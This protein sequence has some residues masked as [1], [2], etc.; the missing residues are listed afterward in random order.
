MSKPNYILQICLLVFFAVTIHENLHAQNETSQWFLYNK[1]HYSFNKDTFKILPNAPVQIGGS[2][3]SISDSA[4][5]MLLVAANG[6]IYDRNYNKLPFYTGANQLYIS[7][8][9]IYFVRKPGSSSQYYFFYTASPSPPQ[10]N[11]Y[12]K[13]IDL[14]LNGGYGD[15]TASDVM[16]DNNCSDGFT[17]I[18]AYKNEEFWIVTHK[19]NTNDFNSRKVTASGINSTPVK[20]TA[21]MDVNTFEYNYHHLK[22]SPNGKFIAGIPYYY[23]SGL[24]PF[25]RR[26]VE[27]YNFNS[28]TGAVTTRV[29][30]IDDGYINTADDDVEFSAD[31]RLLYA[32]Y[33]YYSP[34]LQPCGFAGGNIWQYNL[35][36]T[37]SVS[38]T[39]YKQFL[40]NVFSF[41]V[42][43]LWGNLQLAPD[44]KIYFP[45]SGSG[46]ASSIQN[47]NN[48]GSSCNYKY[49][50][51]GFKNEGS[52]ILPS[53]YHGYLEK[54]VTNNIFYSGGCYPSPLRFS[55]TND[56][57]QFV[58][59]NFDDI[60]SGANNMSSLTKPSH[61]FSSPGFYNVSAVLFSEPGKPFD[62]VYNL[63]EIKDPNKRLLSGFPKDTF[64]C[65]G[66]TVPVH[67]NVVNGIFYWH[68]RQYGRDENIG[69]ADS[70]LIGDWGDGTYIVEMHQNDCDGCILIDSITF[71]T[72]KTP[73]IYLGDTAVLCSGD[74]LKLYA[75]NPGAKTT[76][77]TGETTQNI[78]VHQQGLYWVQQEYNNNGCVRRDSVQVKLNPGV[79]FSLPRDTTLC[80]NETLLLKPGVNNAYYT[81]QDYSTQNTY[82]VTK[83]GKY[84]VRITNFS[85]CTATDTINVSYV[86]GNA[87]Y[88]GKDTTLCEGDSLSLQSNISNANYL[89]STGANTNSISVKTTGDYWVKVS[90]GACTVSD[91]INVKF[92]KK[93]VFSLGNDTTLCDNI[94]LTLKSAITGSYLWQDGSTADNYTV[95][96][97]GLYWLQLTQNN[98]P[99]TDSIKINYKPAP[100]LDLGN[101]T[102]FCSGGALLL[103]AYNSS[104]ASYIWQN[105]STQSSFLVTQAGI[106]Y[107]HIT[108][109][110]GCTNGDTVNISVAQPPVFSL[111]ADTVLCDTK[112]LDY[113]FNIA[114]ASYRWSDGSAG[115]QYS[116][117]KAGTYWLAVSQSGCSA[118]DTVTVGYKPIPLV[119]LGNDTSLCEGS[120]YLLNAYNTG[121]SYLWQDN[122]AQP[123]YTV[124]KQG[125]YFV[126]VTLDGCTATDTAII[127]Y[128]FKPAFSLGNDTAI[129]PGQTLL[130]QPH[131]GGTLN[132]VWQDG[133]VLDHYT[134][135]G[136]GLYSLRASNQC[137]AATDSVTIATAPCDLEM[138]TAFTPNHD[139]KNDLFRIKYPGFIKDF[140]MIIYNR[141]GAKIFETKDA[142]QGWDGN[143]N[144]IPQN[145]GTYVWVIRLTD[146]NNQ[147]Q[148]SQGLVTLLR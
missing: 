141:W 84:W 36:Y 103:D 42:Y 1:Q 81:W 14:S 119:D 4:E 139:G 87:V 13:L 47:A 18:S 76:W 92:N 80:N 20:S 105:N 61:A 27:V 54:A 37:D 52:N 115:N 66:E 142:L 127:N 137:G 129:C 33:D 28:N 29:K 9:N 44:K 75:D 102:G 95:Q 85:G 57:L 31:S 25:F 123:A 12:Y 46:L 93:P 117:N 21:G 3:T 138:P 5:K 122:S 143:I 17:V 107:V 112:S 90:N 94:K 74:S 109:N 135:T 116:I 144:G 101:D 96:T 6:V 100:P 106:Y 69:T 50:T 11:V 41:C 104:V 7:S 63:V 131:P 30:S 65:E 24:F 68:V 99:F 134:V 98:C 48:I 45:Y 82:L 60:A 148:T 64:L 67:L 59:W 114:G 2:T 62:T 111:G 72:L 89:W 32:K 78:W 147:V 91:T 56:T 88:L 39:N 108:G 15:V 38:F 35:C 121:A 26:F 71:H 70:M 130:L 77:S 125:V 118:A 140:D 43:Y 133:T 120:V 19:K 83:P 40:G 22:A 16:I 73:D 136:A 10:T 53:F 51:P 86:S 79:Q 58:Q 124:I 126:K 110:N 146:Y 132:Y 97:A 8:S 49:S 34:G 55:I 145:T 128:I 113:N 23:Y